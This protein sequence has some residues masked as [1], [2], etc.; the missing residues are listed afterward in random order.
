MILC[1]AL[2]ISS[3]GIAWYWHITTS[4]LLKGID[5]SSIDHRY[6]LQLWVFKFLM[7][8][9]PEYECLRGQLIYG[10]KV[11][12]FIDLRKLA[13]S[14]SIHHQSLTRPFSPQVLI[15]LHLLALYLLLCLPLQPIW[16]LVI[17]LQGVILLFFCNYCKKKGHSKETCLKLQKKNASQQHFAGAVTASSSPSTITAIVPPMPLRLLPQPSVHTAVPPSRGY[18]CPDELE[19]LRCLL[20][21]TVV[22]SSSLAHEGISSS[23]LTSISFPS[24][25]FSPS[26]IV[27]S[28]ATAHMTPNSPFYILYDPSPST[29]KVRVASGD[30]LTVAGVGWILLS[31][32]TTL[33]HVLHVPRLNVHL[34]SLSCLVK[35]LGQSVVFTPTTCFSLDQ[36]SRKMT[37]LAKEHHGLHFVRLVSPPLCTAT[38]AAGNVDVSSSSRDQLWLLH[39]RL[40]HPSFSTLSSMFPRLLH[41]HSVD[42]FVCNSCLAKHHC[43]TYPPT[44]LSLI[45]NNIWGLILISSTPGVRWLVIFVNDATLFMWAYLLNHKSDLTQTF[46]HFHLLISTQFSIPPATSALT[47][48]EIISTLLSPIS[49]I[50]TV[51]SMKPPIPISPSKMVSLSGNFVISLIL[52]TAFSFTWMCL[53]IFWEKPFLPLCIFSIAFPLEFLLHIPLLIASWSIILLLL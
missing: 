18:L 10:E 35:D 15:V 8:L 16:P 23:L 2:L 34:L 21:T 30:L 12:S 45:H 42:S 5:P 47:M 38:G 19:R 52:P 20:D 24:Q 44:P 27:D 53:S 37:S 25:S 33:S 22:V 1:S 14:W 39:H 29:H 46:I 17:E 43:A 7:G 6:I 32:L 50:P 40:G 3:K 9:N 36:V 26:W 41:G 48:H 11:L 31:S 49:F 51:S 4:S 28:S 13:W